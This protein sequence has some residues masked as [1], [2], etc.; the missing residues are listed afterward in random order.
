MIVWDIILIIT[1][2]LCNT[3]NTQSITIPQ[4]SLHSLSPDAGNKKKVGLVGVVC[5]VDA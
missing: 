1:I 5:V 4:H 3:T 2:L